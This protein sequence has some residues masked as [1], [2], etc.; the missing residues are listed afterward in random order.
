MEIYNITLK[1][2]DIKKLTE[3]DFKQIVKQKVDRKH[4]KNV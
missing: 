2:E 1:D 3:S 4:L